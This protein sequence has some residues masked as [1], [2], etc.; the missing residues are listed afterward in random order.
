MFEE[1]TNWPH[2]IWIQLYRDNMKAQRNEERICR[3]NLFQTCN[4]VL[5]I[6]HV[7]DHSSFWKIFLPPLIRPVL[8][9]AIRPTFLPLEVSLLMVDGWP[10]CCW[11]PP[12]WGCSTGFIATPLSLGQFFLFPLNLYHDLL[13]L[14]SGLSVLCPPATTPIIALQVPTIVFLV[15]DGSLIL[16][17]LRSSEWPM[18][19]AE[20]PEA[21]AKD[22]L[23]PCLPSQLET[24]VPSGSELTGRMFPIEREAIW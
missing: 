3:V 11:L 1:E 15:P 19:M 5:W 7:W 10:I 6:D 23:S 17:F 12:P 24:M 20:V 8:L 2:I 21:L 18:T 16:V 4:L 14:R 13:A 22:P 9:A